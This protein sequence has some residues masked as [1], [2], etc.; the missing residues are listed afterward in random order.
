[1]RIENTTLT[2]VKS[3]RIQF[4]DLWFFKNYT[5]QSISKIIKY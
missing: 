5:I 4:I 3:E 2:Y 1:M